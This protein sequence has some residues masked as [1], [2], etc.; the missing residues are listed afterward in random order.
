MKFRELL[1]W[2][3]VG[4]LVVLLLWLLNVDSGEPRVIEKHTT[5][6]LII[7]VVDTVTITKVKTVVKEKVDT[8]YV[9][10]RDSIY[11]PIFLNE[12]QFKEE[13]LFDFRVK[14][15]DVEFISAE[16]YQTTIRETIETTTN[17]TES[18]NKSA[19]FIYGGFSAICDTFYPR[20]GLALSLK[21]KW[22]IS[23]DISYF[24]KHPLWGATVGYNILNK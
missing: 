11:F 3:I 23:A 22:L 15:Y 20:G 16:V 24:Q 7:R 6:T 17:V 2:A 5:D 18:K 4:V 12:Y 13:G 9:C 21:N 1:P 14:G 19:L 8:Q 10:V